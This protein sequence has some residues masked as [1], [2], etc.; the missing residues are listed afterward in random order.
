MKVDFAL[1]HTTK[2]CLCKHSHQ[3]EQC[4]RIHCRGKG[5]I[6]QLKEHALEAVQES[7]KNRS[8]WD[9]AR[10]VFQNKWRKLKGPEREESIAHLGHWRRSCLIT[11]ESKRGLTR[12]KSGR[13]HVTEFQPLKCELRPCNSPV[14]FPLCSAIM[15]SHVKYGDIRN[16]LLSE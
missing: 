14:L 3:H 8:Y 11:A 15:V 5:S 4:V 2:I 1:A 7:E 16:S 6:I 12:V 9:M 10:E 13:E